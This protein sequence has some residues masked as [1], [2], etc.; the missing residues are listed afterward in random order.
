MEFG[1]S[2]LH[3]I[4]SV[5]RWYSS[6]A[7]QWLELLPLS[8]LK[9]RYSSSSSLAICGSVFLWSL[10]FPIYGILPCWKHLHWTPQRKQVRRQI[11]RYTTALLCCTLL[12]TRHFNSRLPCKPGL[13]GCPLNFLLPLV[14]NPLSPQNT[15][16][17][18]CPT[19]SHH[20]FLLCHLCFI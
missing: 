16:K 20:V 4:W 18:F 6:P 8:L 10:K 17:L 3:G 19:P 12:Y 11:K 15:I 2:A 5:Q 9:D 14:S 7:R 13:P 1:F